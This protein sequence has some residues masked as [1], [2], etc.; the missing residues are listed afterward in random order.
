[1]LKQ[2][3]L[4]FFLCSTLANAAIAQQLT[5]PKS[6]IYLFKVEQ[7]GDGSLSFAQP[8]YLTAFNPEGYNNNPSFFSNTELYISVREPGSTQADLYKL[9]LEHHTR[10][11]VTATPESEIAPERMPEYYTFSAVRAERNGQEEALK[12]W[13]FPVDQLTNGKPVF[14][15]LT[16]I[17]DYL[18]L[19][20][21]EIAIY[22]EDNPSALSIVNTN[23][24]KMETLATNV[25]PCLQRLPNGNLVYVQKSRYDDWKIMEKN[26]FR[27]KEPARTIIETLPNA[28]HFAVLPDGSLLMAKGSKIYRFNKFTDDNWKEVADLR[29]YEIRNISRLVVSTDF[30][31]AVVAD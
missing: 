29:F 12:L 4:L 26:L 20:S 24:D 15:Y 13:Q 18:W 14:K 7:E 9:D 16:G 17:S 21:Q 28:D 3:T 5:F 11:Q 19:S 25:G 6:N 10:L 23:D 30:Q 27:R 1:M 22:K 31:I 8:R 2:T